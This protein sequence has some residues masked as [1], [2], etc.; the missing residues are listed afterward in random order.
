M[1]IESMSKTIPIKRIIII[2]PLVCGIIAAIVIF[3][4]SQSTAQAGPREQAKRIHERLAGVSPSESVLSTMTSQLNAG[5]GIDASMTAME[6]PHF[7]DVALKNF[8]TPWTNE[9]G[10][11]YEPLNDYTATVIGIIRDDIDFREILSADI[12]YTADPALGLPSYS[13]SNN[14]LYQALEEQRIDLQANLIQTTQSSVTGL[15][16]AATAGVTTT[17]AAAKSFFIDGT[18]RAMFRFTLINQLCT[19][20]EPLKDITRSPDRI[21]QDVSRSPGG[22][23]RIFLN[24]CIG[25]HTGMDPLAQAYAYYEFDHD[26]DNDPDGNNGSLSYNS[27]GDID[28]DTGSRVKNKY[29]INPNNF[30]FGFITEN[31]NWDN[32]WRAGQN[33]NLGWSNALTGSGQGAKSMGVE[34]ANSEAFASC[35]VKKVF[36]QVCLRPAVD[37]TDRNQIDSMVTSFKSNSYSL[38]QV[39]AESALYCMGD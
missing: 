13:N 37:A 22:D 6:N 35:Q 16:E 19:D 25:C 18:N 15:P 36:K 27:S 11:T 29:Q 3:F 9:A 38:K 8:I 30:K 4:L 17:R 32:Y 1:S 10:S 7:Y 39:F 21:R 23:S 5:N 20:L 31:D 14:N 28:A 33:A 12:L 2:P 26:S 34:L 24:N